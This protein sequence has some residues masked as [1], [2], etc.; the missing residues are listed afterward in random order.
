MA[1]NIKIIGNIL[2]TTTVSRYSAE[3][4]NLIISRNLQE[5]FG[6]TNDYIEY[7]IYDAGGNLLNTNYNYLSYKLPPSTGLTPS[8]VPQ[9]NVQGNIQTT[10]V[11]VTST[12]VPQTSSLYPIIEID[13]VKDLQDLGYSSGEFNVRYNFLNNKISNYIN[14]ALFVKEISSDR[15]EIRLASTTLTNDEIES[16]TNSIIDEINN[17]PYTVDYLLNFGNNEQYVTINVAL[18]KATT[19]YEILF[20][21]YQ[22]LPLT[23]QEKLTLWVV[24][25]KVNPY[26]FDINLDKLI[27]A[28]PAPRLRGPNFDIPVD[29]QGTIS[30]SYNTYSN[31]VSNLQSLQSSSYTQILNLLNSQSID[32]NVDYTNF[33]NFI[34][35]GSAKQ[36]VINFYNKVKQ[37]EDYNTLITTYKAQ[38]GTIPSLQTEINLYS[39]SINNIITQLDGFES[40]MYFESTSYTWP[41]VNSIKPYTLAPT[42]SALSWYNSLT[43]SATTY[44]LDNPDNLEY[45][46]PAFIKDDIN[47]QPFLYFLNMTGHYFDNIWIYLKSVTDINV[48]NNNLDKGISKDLV[49][50]RLRSMGVKLYNSQA[51]ENVNQYLVGANTGSNVFDNNFSITGSYLNNIPRKDLVSELYKRI[52][53]NLP[54]LLKTKGTVSGLEYLNTIFGITGSVVNVKEFGGTTKTELIKGY[55]SNKVRIIDNAV[56]GTVLSSE[57]SLQSFPTSSNLFRDE[58]THYIDISF[59]PE[60]QIDTYV[61]KS[62][63]SNNPTFNLDDYIGDPRQQYSSSYIDLEAQKTLYFQTGV[64]GYPGFTGSLMDYN[65]FIRLIQYFDNSLFKMLADFVPERASLSTGVT[66]NSPVLERNK[67]VYSIPSFS[68]QTVYDAQYPT[69]SISSDYGFMYDKLSG[70]KKPFYTGEL[71]GS[72]IDLYNT[73]FIPSNF[74]P[75][76]Q[77]S[78]SINLNTFKHSNFNVLLNNISSSVPSLVRRGIEYFYGTT[79]SI[80]VPVELQDSYLSLESYNTSRYEGSKTTSLL[81]NTYTSASTT[82]DGDY[83][84]GKT[85]A[86]DHNVRKLGLFTQISSNVF[87]PG[88]NN[89]VLKYLVDEFGGLTELNQRNKHWCEVQNT[90]VASELT[91]VSLFD[92]KKYSNQKFTDGNKL[93]FDS[94]YSYPPILYFSSSCSGDY[95]SFQNTNGTNAYLSTAQN[96]LLS[97]A[98]VSG[99]N[100]GGTPN[101]AY[102]LSASYVPR[103]FNQVTYGSS[104]LSAGNLISHPSY[105]V[106]ETGNHLINI[107]LPFTIEANAPFTTVWSLQVWVSGSTRNQIVTGSDG[108]SF[109]IDNQTFTTVIPPTTSYRLS[110]IVFDYNNPYRICTSGIELTTWVSQDDW[111]SIQAIGNVLNSGKILYADRALTTRRTGYEYVLYNAQTNNLNKTTGVVGTSSGVPQ[112]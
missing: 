57:L 72:N 67:V 7:F 37:I 26:I 88:R 2:N 28:A 38:V 16:I 59:S 62:I 33:N 42:S 3:D 43:A 9:P 109:G 71:S 91:N 39:S 17:S 11:G 93:I 35:F 85:A 34:F 46:I 102:P 29:N 19:G 8:T 80:L 61:S 63:A 75:Y 47:N 24:G 4:T 1:D 69:S 36:R 60:T 32:I 50:D 104:Y 21:L 73:Y 90:F 22:P 97:N 5:N 108:T 79:G 83:S 111:D 6:G 54:L 106:Q 84:Y 44:D 77:P 78:S 56:Q 49:Y 25:E 100:S 14:E 81:Y 23:I 112:C 66:I 27:I 94:G 18:N 45:A 89:V 20:K 99:S 101:N 105:S 41:K 31:L 103:I 48:A 68:K 98:Y 12:S 95:L 76:L 13:P 53:H 92:N 96:S 64:S 70:D 65:G 10:N 87:L 55:N 52:Y 86:I 110:G 51:G 40:Y 30:T 58:D 74:N 82:Y 107:S 15:T